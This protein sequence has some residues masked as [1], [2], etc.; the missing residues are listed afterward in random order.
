MEPAQLRGAGDHGHGPASHG[1]LEYPQSDLPREQPTCERRGGRPRRNLEGVAADAAISRA[2][3]GGLPRHPS[4]SLGGNYHRWFNP[5]RPRAGARRYRDCPLARLDCGAAELASAREVAG[6][7]AA[8]ER[9]K[10]VAAAA[11]EPGR[12]K[13]ERCAAGSAKTGRTRRIADAASRQWPWRDRAERLRQVVARP[14][15]GW[16]LGTDTRKDLP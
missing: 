7:G 15:A 10:A 8:G 6:G 2:R 12:R 5:Q 13:R 3:S 4:G 1:A 9:A 16:I 14:H 11:Q